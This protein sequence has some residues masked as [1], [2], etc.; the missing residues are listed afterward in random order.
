MAT[1]CLSINLQYSQQIRAPRAVFVKFPHGASFGEP[2]QVD[3][4]LTLLRDLFWAL[5]R[6]EEPGE[7]VEPGYRWRRSSYD[8]VD[9]ASFQL[10]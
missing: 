6:L 3:Q 2:G 4:Q 7:I 10:D 1:V 8:P 5:Q 9:L